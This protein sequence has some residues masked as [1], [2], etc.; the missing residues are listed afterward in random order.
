MDR[1]IPPTVKMPTGVEVHGG[2][3]RI[4]FMYRGHRCRESLGVPPTKA[5]I[6]KASQQR[7]HITYLIRTGAFDYGEAFP[8]S[9][10]LARFGVNSATITVSQLAQRW[11]RYKALD[12]SNNTHAR[13]TSM[14][15]TIV[16]YM[17]PDRFC[18]DLRQQDFAELR[19]QLLDA[20]QNHTNRAKSGRTVR[21]VNT[22]LTIARQMFE[23]ALSNDIVESRFW[24][25][26]KQLKKTRSKPEPLST[27]EFGRLLAACLHPQD[28]NLIT[29]AVYTGLRHGE[30]ISL[31]WEDIDL[32]RREL[33]V[34]RNLASIGEF[35]QPK[36]ESGERVIKLL[37]PAVEA[38][39][40]QQAITKLYPSNA[41]NVVLR[42][43]RRI[44][45]DHCTFVF[46]P[47]V[48]AR[49][50]YEKPHYSNTSL[51]DK[52][53]RICKRAGIKRRPPYQTRHTF[54]CWMLSNG[55]NPAYIA[56]Q[57]GHSTAQMVFNVYGDWIPEND[58]NQVAMLE[59]SLK[60]SAPHM[61]HK[62]TRNA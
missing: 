46:N 14:L 4:W 2:S 62:K 18:S 40:A 35:V 47:L 32:T 1:P 15:K 59:A 22:Y 39:Q 36:T 44:R 30:L 6:K 17:G 12:I 52:W 51:E 34:S 60:K 8:E 3:L 10:N 11:L 61:P 57:M 29:V 20:P 38:L 26:V 9:P 24:E 7:S 19:S 50:E 25:S 53:T 27:D 5:N 13:Y 33:K 55:A 48:T 43:K 54:A 37:S 21:T 28:A 58:A 56:G 49:G 45:I 41:I 16:N 42:E 23:F 31:A